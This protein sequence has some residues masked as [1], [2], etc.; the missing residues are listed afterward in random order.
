MGV[1]VFLSFM[2]EVKITVN[3]DVLDDQLHWALEVC[4]ALLFRQGNFSIVVL[5]II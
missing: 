2:N 3:F 5:G 1:K 4:L